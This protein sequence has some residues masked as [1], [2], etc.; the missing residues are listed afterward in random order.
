MGVRR[1]KVEGIDTPQLVRHV[2][3]AGCSRQVWATCRFDRQ[4]T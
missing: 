3:I 2:E 1:M 4:I